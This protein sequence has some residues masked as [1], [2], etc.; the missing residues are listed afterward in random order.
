MR[1]NIV[2]ARSTQRDSGPVILVLCADADVVSL[3]GI[4]VAT[5]ATALQFDFM[6]VPKLI[7]SSGSFGH[8]FSFVKTYSSP[9]LSTV[10]LLMPEVMSICAASEADP[11]DLQ[12]NFATSERKIV[13]REA[14]GGTG[15]GG[16]LGHL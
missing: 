2:V 11:L 5:S 15:L 6:Q 9:S 10:N 1:V 13:C 12:I 7:V 8:G 3:T 14:S 16:W 4:T